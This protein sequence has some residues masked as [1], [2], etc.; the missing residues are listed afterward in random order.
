MSKIIWKDE[1]LVNVKEIDKQHKKLVEI[2]NDLYANIIEGA[3]NSEINQIYK[4]LIDYAKLHFSTE[5]KYFKKFKYKDGESHTAEHE[6]FTK[7]IAEFRKKTGDMQKISFELLDFLEDW[8]VDHL[9][10]TD[11]KYSKFFN[12]KGL[13]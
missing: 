3:E 7:E 1:Y 13:K 5:E 2:I 11:Q 10:T 8:L 4:R 9:I 6:K 12:E